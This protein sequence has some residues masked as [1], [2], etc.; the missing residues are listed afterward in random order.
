MPSHDEIVPEIAEQ[1][2]ARAVFEQLH[3]GRHPHDDRDWGW[4]KGYS[5]ALARRRLADRRPVDPEDTTGVLTLDQ[6]IDNFGN[7]MVVWGEADKNSRDYDDLALAADR[8]RQTLIAIVRPISNETDTLHPAKVSPS[9]LRI[10]YVHNGKELVVGGEGGE[11]WIA[12]FADRHMAVHFVGWAKERLFHLNGR[13]GTQNALATA[14]CPQAGELEYHAALQ[15]AQGVFERYKLE[16][17]SYWGKMKDAPIIN[18]VAAR[19]AEAFV[20]HARRGEA[21][22]NPRRAGRPKTLLES[23][24][25]II[26]AY[27]NASPHRIEDARLWLKRYVDEGNRMPRP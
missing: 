26:Y 25:P 8:A 17:A 20:T 6:A 14:E 21:A 27:A 15:V 3:N 18:D 1:N 22:N 12:T 11:V 16:W 5:I 4:I 19:M 24:G 23:A 7:A 13:R 10:L 2:E 9:T